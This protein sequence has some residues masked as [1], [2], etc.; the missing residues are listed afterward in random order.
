MRTI[1]RTRIP[2]F[3]LLFFLSVGLTSA[4]SLFETTLVGSWELVEQAVNAEGQPCPFVPDA[5]EFFSDGTLAMSN[6]PGRRLPFKTVV[7]KE[8]R[9]SI[10]ERIPSLAGAPLLLVKPVPQMEWRNTPITYS[11][12]LD[13]NRLT[14][15]VIGWSPAT[16]EK[17]R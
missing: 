9:Q 13:K 1:L 4:Q 3:I 7:T 8:E 15:T 6:M 14:L 2:L 16:F 17:V 12:S 5:I 11:Y 10:E